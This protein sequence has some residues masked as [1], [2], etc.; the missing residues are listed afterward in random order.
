MVYRYKNE[1]KKI[2]FSFFTDRTTLVVL[3]K[4]EGGHIFYILEQ[5]TFFLVGLWGLA[6]ME[7]G[8]NCSW[9]AMIGDGKKKTQLRIWKI[10]SRIWNKK[11][12]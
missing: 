12:F 11:V 1:K 10:V 8:R 3:A 2:G 6:M 5:I 7:H 9:E 4:E